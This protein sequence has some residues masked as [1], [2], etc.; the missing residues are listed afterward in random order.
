EAARTLVGAPVPEDLRQALARATPSGTRAWI[1]L[2][3]RDPTALVGPA[4]MPV[5]SARWQLLQHRRVELLRAT[6]ADTH[7]EESSP[8]Q[9]PWQ[10]ACRWG[11]EPARRG[12]T[13]FLGG[14]RGGEQGK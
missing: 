8:W 14:R 13:A 1:A 9:R 3:L 10:L 6:L 4:P 2:R 7:G 12:A 5:L 11:W